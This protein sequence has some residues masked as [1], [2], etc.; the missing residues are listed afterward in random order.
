MS[1]PTGDTPEKVQQFY[2]YLNGHQETT[3]PVQTWHVDW[4]SLAWLWGFASILILVLLLWVKQYRTTR[5]HAG[6]YPVDSF[7]GWTTEAARPATRFFL[8]LTAIVIGFAVALIV[9][10]IVWGQKF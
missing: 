5:Q 10:H 9:G 2:S 8:L 1:M 4:M 7:G 3:H 6:I